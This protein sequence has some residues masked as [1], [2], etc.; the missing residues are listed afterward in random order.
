MT[1]GHAVL[2]NSIETIQK[3][4]FSLLRMLI[5]ANVISVKEC[6]A[7]PSELH[8]ALRFERSSMTESEY[9]LDDI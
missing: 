4:S 3:N 1:K 5:F 2:K 9:F 8:H 7:T 6:V